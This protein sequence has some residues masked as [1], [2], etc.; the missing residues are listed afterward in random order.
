MTNNITMEEN[1]VKYYENEIK[2]ILNLTEVEGKMEIVEKPAVEIASA[3]KGL[4]EK[5]LTEEKDK[6]REI[7][8]LYI[9][10]I[11]TNRVKLLKEL[12]ELVPLQEV[13]MNS[14]VFLNEIRLK[15]G[16]LLDKIYC[17]AHGK[18]SKLDERIFGTGISKE[19]I[20]YCLDICNEINSSTILNI[21]N[22]YMG[23]NYINV[24]L[25]YFR[26]K[27]I[28]IFHKVVE[29]IVEEITF[30]NSHRKNHRYDFIRRIFIEN[31]NTR[32]FDGKTILMK[33]PI[34]TRLFLGELEELKDEELVELLSIKDYNSMNIMHI[35]AIKNMFSTLNNLRERVEQIEDER[36]YKKA[37][38][39]FTARDEFNNQ[40]IN[41]LKFNIN[42]LNNNFNLIEGESYYLDAMEEKQKAKDEAE[43]QVV[44]MKNYLEEKGLVSQENERGNYRFIFS[45]SPLDQINIYLDH[46]IEKHELSYSPK[47]GKLLSNK[48]LYS[49]FKS[50]L[51]KDRILETRVNLKNFMK[52]TDNVNDAK[53]RSLKKHVEQS[54]DIAGY[55]SVNFIN[56]LG[57]SIIEQDK[58]QEII[59]KLSLIIN[60]VKEW[61]WMTGYSIQEDYVSDIKENI[62]LTLAIECHRK[63]VVTK[64]SIRL[65]LDEQKLLEGEEY[66]DLYSMENHIIEHTTGNLNHF[67][68]KRREPKILKVLGELS[69]A[70]YGEDLIELYFEL[71]H[72]ANKQNLVRYDETK[73]IEEFVRK[74]NGGSEL[75]EELKSIKRVI[76]KVKPIYS[77]QTP[78]ESAKKRYIDL[79]IGLK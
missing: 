55:K 4:I 5:S 10:M 33:N 30:N 65:N 39:L 36:L 50:N 48:E 19:M 6:T 42:D 37:Q 73:A 45:A 60:R 38:D 66:L 14:T 12:E 78:K 24:M 58:K 31:M 22:S 62:L 7:Q 59:D 79:K 27:E 71:Y 18:S 21:L 53:E 8:D 28:G 68:K 69:E 56:R 47:C 32:D 74:N 61:D 76:A 1:A 52:L 41:Y 70:L 46:L 67:F 26:K 54:Y 29:R 75:L 72:M 57:Y 23:E 34:F 49:K 77:I 40:V 16:N 11:E 25:D 20:E 17:G 44:E 63:I 35:L 9:Y 13:I 2:I 15:S 3:I 43:K 51:G 64:D